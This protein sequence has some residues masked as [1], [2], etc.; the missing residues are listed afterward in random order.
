MLS[1]THAYNKVGNA[2]VNQPSAVLFGIG[3]GIT[4]A[5]F[6]QHFY[7]VFAFHQ[8]HQVIIAD[9]SIASINE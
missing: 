8:F 5:V 4:H 3:V 2:F 9:D 6:L 1:E 7:A